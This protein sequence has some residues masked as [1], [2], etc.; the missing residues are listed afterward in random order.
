MESTEPTEPTEPTKPTKPTK[1]TESLSAKHKKMWRKMVLTQHNDVTRGNALRDVWLRS[2][3][4]RAII[5]DVF[6]P[7]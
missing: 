1:S 5:T 7:R 4:P 6:S 2:Q 3:S